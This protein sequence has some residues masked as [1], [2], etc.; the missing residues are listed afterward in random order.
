MLSTEEVALDLIDL[1]KRID[2]TVETQ[3]IDAN[4]LEVIV[5]EVSK[6]SKSSH[7]VGTKKHF[8]VM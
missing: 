5:F 1:T 6:F 4:R 7:A 3:S 8:A 2:A